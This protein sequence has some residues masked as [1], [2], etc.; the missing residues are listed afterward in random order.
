MSGHAILSPSSGDRWLTGGC[1]GSPALNYGREDNGSVYAD[2]GTAA[3]ALLEWCLVNEKDANDF[4]HAVI[5]V[6]SDGNA[7]YGDEIK[8]AP[9]FTIRNS[10]E[11]DDEMREHVQ[12][13]VDD[14]RLHAKGNEII[15]EQRV[16]F[17]N[18][19]GVPEEFG[20]G[21]ADARVRDEAE[22][23]LQVHDL[24]YGASPKGIVH[25]GTPD[26]PNPQLALY[27]LG[28][29]EEDE[30][31]GDYDVVELHVHQ[32]RLNHKDVVRVPIADMRAFAQSAKARAA[33][34]MQG[35]KHNPYSG[36]LM[37][38][39][40]GELYPRSMED[41][42]AMGMLQPSPKGCHYCAV[43]DTCLALK[44][45][46]KATVIDYFD[47]IE[48]EV[49]DPKTPGLTKRDM[50]EYLFAKPVPSPAD[51]ALLETFV[52]AVTTSVRAK[53]KAGEQVEG[54]KLVKGKKGPRA[55]VKSKLAEIEKLFKEK[56]RLKADEMYSKKLVTPTQ[57]EKLLKDSPKRWEQI[58]TADYITQSEGSETLAAADDKREAVKHANVR[59]LFET[60]DDLV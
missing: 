31:L 7:W 57:A 25:A 17:H 23:S 45:K 48:D 43:A 32:P 52:E 6:Q 12:V 54:W 56:F 24:K 47:V 29:L 55:W 26:K 14:I 41:L 33:E 5:H 59:D 9:Y 20:N 16:Y 22:R 46:N 38:G 21:T 10:F 44:R 18:T 37:R 13:V 49:P 15:A 19:L 58:N 42:D 2:E 39:P 4:P 3:H 11:A 51:L 40:N 60:I 35:F 27:G 28:A 53:L 36:E 50:V 8:E 34:A 30:L 1:T